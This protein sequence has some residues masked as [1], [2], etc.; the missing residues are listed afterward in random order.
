[1]G[2]PPL[3]VK[4]TLV[5]LAEDAGERIDA[6]VGKNRRAEFIRYA[7]EKELKLLER[8]KRKNVDGTTPKG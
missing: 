2:R 8:S 1:M 7:V 3:K 6:L 5:R 4:A